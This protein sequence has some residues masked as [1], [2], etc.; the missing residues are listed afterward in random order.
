VTTNVTSARPAA[1][2]AAKP[3]TIKDKEFDFIAQQ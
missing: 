3:S 2:P 1:A